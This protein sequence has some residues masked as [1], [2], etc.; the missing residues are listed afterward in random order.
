[1]GTSYASTAIRRAVGV[2]GHGDGPSTF[3]ISASPVSGMCV[4]LVLCVG[5]ALQLEC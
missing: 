3:A 2:R 5:G 4:V 1:M